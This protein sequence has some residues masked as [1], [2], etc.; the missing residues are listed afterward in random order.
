[1]ALTP[2]QKQDIAKRLDA[3]RPAEDNISANTPQ[4]ITLM[5]ARF[6]AGT[7]DI[8]GLVES[9]VDRGKLEL[10][11]QEHKTDIPADE[12]ISQIRVMEKFLQEFGPLIQ[13]YRAPGSPPLSS[14]NLATRYTEL[15]QRF[16]EM[17]EQVLPTMVEDITGDQDQIMI[18]AA[19]IS[20]EAEAIESP[21][22]TGSYVNHLAKAAGFNPLAFDVREIYSL[23]RAIEDINPAAS[24]V[25]KAQYPD[26]VIAPAAPVEIALENNETPTVVTG[27]SAMEEAKES[28]SE[29]ASAVPADSSPAA[30]IAPSLAVPAAVIAQQ[31][32]AE[33]PPKPEELK[34]RDAPAVVIAAPAAPATSS[35]VPLAPDVLKRPAEVFSA[36]VNAQAGAGDEPSAIMKKFRDDPEVL[37]DYARAALKRYFSD[38]Q[39]AAVLAQSQKDFARRG[40]V[41]PALKTLLREIR[42]DPDS[43]SAQAA[44]E[45]I[46]DALSLYAGAARAGSS[47]ALRDMIDMVRQGGIDGHS[48]KKLGIEAV[49]KPDPET[50]YGMIADARDALLAQKAFADSDRKDSFAFAANDQASL[51]ALRKMETEM[52]R[53]FKDIEFRPEPDSEALKDKPQ[54]SHRGM[55][56]S[57]LS[58]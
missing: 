1:M 12:P 42:K 43:E 16:S 47:Q 7:A 24:E 3:N 38:G 58:I 10:F 41:E 29:P 32:V 8:P 45:R 53:D 18:I 28:K 20:A 39:S 26:R 14:G 27:A 15:D 19:A 55:D 52:R 21:D 5:M 31:E 34:G 51:R 30:E 37:S 25:L 49:D 23:N 35:S 4:N 56:Y 36:S 40:L 22:E 17:R 6:L 33:K 57:G 44:R 11:M 13:P 46:G 50:L 54:L 9:E 2:Q 48:W